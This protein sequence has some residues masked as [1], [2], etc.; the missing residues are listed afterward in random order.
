MALQSLNHVTLR[1]HDLE[2]TRDF[3][4]DIVGLKEGERPPFGFPGYWL[5]VGEMPVIHLVGK[6]NTTDD[7]A[8]YEGP[9]DTAAGSGAIDHVAFQYD[10]E[11]YDKTLA[12]IER[13]G[14]QSHSQTVP[15][16][17]LRQLFIKDPDEV[18]V[19]INFLAT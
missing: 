4:V 12:A 13:L 8:G 11:D 9:T 2:A 14:F 7:F 17:G 3:Y 19:E 5:Y 1:P 15:D 18:M 16:L 6:G 10:A